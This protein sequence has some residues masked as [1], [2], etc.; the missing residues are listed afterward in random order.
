MLIRT[1][2]VMC[3]SYKKHFLAHNMPFV[4]IKKDFE[5]TC[6]K[7]HETFIYFC[8]CHPYGDRPPYKRCEC[9]NSAPSSRCPFC[10]FLKCCLNERTYK[11]YLEKLPDFM[12][13]RVTQIDKLLKKIPFNPSIWFDEIWYA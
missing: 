3:P 12:T 1:K 4:E 6:K 13:Y 10:Y 11:V 5:C 9:V 8:K 2:I 7:P